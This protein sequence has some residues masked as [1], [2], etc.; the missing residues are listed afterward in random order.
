MLGR[1]QP[2][3]IYQ[4]SPTERHRSGAD[5]ELV[6]TV[7]HHGRGP[8]SGHYTADVC[9]PNGQWLRFDDA[10]VSSVPLSRV[11]DASAYLLFYQLVS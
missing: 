3:W 11:L 10:H 6:A 9:Q 7:S 4:A 1:L 5:Y 2:K 8:A